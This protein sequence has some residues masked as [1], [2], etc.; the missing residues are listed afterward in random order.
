MSPLLWFQ[1]ALDG[2]YGLSALWVS[3]HVLW[4]HM[5]G[6]NSYLSPKTTD[7]SWFLAQPPRKGTGIVA[8]RKCCATGVSRKS[9]LVTDLSGD[10]KQMVGHQQTEPDLLE[11]NIW[12]VAKSWADR[13]VGAVAYSTLINTLRPGQN[14]GRQYPN[15]IFKCIFWKETNSYFWMKF[16]KETNSYFWIKISMKFIYL[17]GGVCS[18]WQ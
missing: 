13:L 12:S 7:S 1:C 11:N 3:C 18:N 8:C 4:A 14:N 17:G 5:T 15:N 10:A 6:G 2:G 9:H 16:W